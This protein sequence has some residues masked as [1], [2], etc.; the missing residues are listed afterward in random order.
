MKYIKDK[1]ASW[2]KANNVLAQELG[3]E[4]SAPKYCG[5]TVGVTYHSEGLIKTYCTINSW[6]NGEGYDLHFLTEG[7]KDNWSAKR[8][9]LHSDEL[10]AM[11]KCLEHLKYFEL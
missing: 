6:S 3:Y 9:E 11:F 10:T 4:S 1:I 8:I 2:M 5:D 7:A